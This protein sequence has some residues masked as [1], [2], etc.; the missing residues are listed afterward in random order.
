MA[1]TD[2]PNGFN[3]VK[4]LAGHAELVQGLVAVSTKITKGDAVIEDATSA[5][6]VDVAATDSDLLLGI[7]AE[8]VSTTASTTDTVLFYP[9]IPTNIFEAQTDGT[10]AQ[11]QMYHECDIIGSTG[12]FEINEDDS[13][14]GVCYIV[15]KDP[16]SE[17]GD[18][19]RVHVS[20]IRSSYLPL[21]AAK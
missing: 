10:F 18:N 21:L 12:I 11:T 6:Y 3:F 7:A 14:E 19:T 8:S 17:I 16:N 5:G 13:T 4:S 15:G 20:I 9:G 2:N 1:N